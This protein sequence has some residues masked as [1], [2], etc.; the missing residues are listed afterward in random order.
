MFYFIFRTLPLLFVNVL[1]L[2][3][4]VLCLFPGFAHFAWYYFVTSDR[5]TLQYGNDSIRQK[6][7]V[8]YRSCTK[9]DDGEQQEGILG[10]RRE[11]AA[12]EEC[13]RSSPAPVIIFCTGGAWIIGYKMWGALLARAM[14]AAGIVVVIP[15][16]RNYP[17]V[18]V[19]TMV[20][21]VDL[22]IDWTMKNIS[23]YG[24]DPTNVVVVGQSAGGH[25]A[26]M[27]IFRNMRKGI[28]REEKRTNK[29]I[30]ITREEEELSERKGEE[31]RWML[32]EKL[33][34]EKLK[35]EEEGW[36]ASD[37]KGFIAISSPL[38]LGSG[39]LT[40]SFQRLGFDDTM[41]HRMFGFET[42]QY[43]PYLVIKK[44][45]FFTAKE[46]DQHKKF[47]QNLPPISIYHGK[48]DKTVPYEV[49]ETFYRELLR[50]APISPY[51]KGNS[52]LFVPYDGWSHT[53]PIL[54]GPM[55]ADQRLHKDILN[56]VN[57]WTTSSPDLIW[58]NDHHRVNDRLC[59]HFM[60]KLS[61]IINPF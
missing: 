6:V 18:C 55:D 57:K 51:C 29:N 21:D 56:D 60:I 7:D 43:D 52:V 23:Q 8:Y 1:R 20:D 15:D 3:L 19:P 36:S 38:N 61:R 42:E 14:T 5:I 44:Q 37:L 34:D 24:G 28:A 41:I 27:T 33:L 17:F 10:G 4:F 13:R 39:L 32:D 50:A 47:L 53:D 22:A 45:T 26:C 40:P 2:I 31:D 30:I 58:P 54:E 16:M 12:E 46:A 48:E 49:S 11:C 35:E 59:P 25:V 9:T